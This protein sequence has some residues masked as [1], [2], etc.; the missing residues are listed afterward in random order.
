MDTISLTYEHRAFVAQLVGAGLFDS[1]AD[2]VE[3]ALERLRDE[4]LA[5]QE[6]ARDLA[7][8]LEE[9]RAAIFAGDI[10]EAG[11]VFDW[12]VGNIHAHASKR[13]VVE[14]GEQ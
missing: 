13:A 5:R 9:G 10:V 4:D 6:R 14:G 3:A 11:D 1:S 8:K 12:I 2:V 7:L